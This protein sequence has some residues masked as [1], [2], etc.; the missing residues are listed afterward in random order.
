[1]EWIQGVK[2]T[3]LEPA[4]IRD[5]VKVGQEAFLIQLLEVRRMEE[6]PCGVGGGFEFRTHFTTLPDVRTSPSLH[7]PFSA[8][9][10][11]IG[12]FHGDPHPGAYV[13][14]K[15]WKWRLATA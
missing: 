2:L 15:G 10:T 3:T 7:L 11:Q 13:W 6:S 9:L 4:E 5:L 12:F 1:M 14:R 8:P